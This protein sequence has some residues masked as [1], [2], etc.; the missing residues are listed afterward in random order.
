M[1]I[2]VVEALTVPYYDRASAMWK[3]RA[4]NL[5]KARQTC[6][7]CRLAKATILTHWPKLSFLC[8]SKVE[9]VSDKTEQGTVA[10]LQSSDA[11]YV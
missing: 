4:H 6:Y 9:E 7:C 11:Y 3:C 2:K 8:I 5:L 10:A 1:Y